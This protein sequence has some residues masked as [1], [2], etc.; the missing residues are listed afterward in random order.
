[1]TAP[2]F[3]LSDDEPTIERRWSFTIPIAVP[4][5][6]ELKRAAYS[7]DKSRYKR[8]RTDFGWLVKSAAQW[9]PKATAPRKVRITRLMGKNGKLYDHDNFVS[10][11]KALLDE[12]VAFGLLV[13]DSAEWV[14]ATYAQEKAKEHGTKVELEDA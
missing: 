14:T 1:V 12:L 5:A 11:C 9:V 7:G 4:S 6:N 2:V 8:L 13:D 3:D 10:A